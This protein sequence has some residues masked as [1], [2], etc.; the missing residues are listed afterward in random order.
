MAQF[1]RDQNGNINWQIDKILGY[2]CKWR[3]SNVTFNLLIRLVGFSFALTIPLI[4]IAL[5]IQWISTPWSEL[6]YVYA[7]EI[8]IVLL[9]ILRIFPR[10]IREMAC[11]WEVQLTCGIYSYT[12]PTEIAPSYEEQLRELIEF[13]WGIADPLIGSKIRLYPMEFGSDIRQGLVSS[14][15]FK[16]KLRGFTDSVK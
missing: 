3:L 10:S 12:S 14:R 11:E 2:V 8:A 13:K 5:K 15:D 4:I 9:N 7:R 16:W 1:P 6:R